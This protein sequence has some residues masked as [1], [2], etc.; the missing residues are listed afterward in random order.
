MCAWL[1]E[2][3]GSSLICVTKIGHSSTRHV[4]SCASQHTEHQHK[5]SLTYV[6]CVTF[7]YLSDSRLCCPRIHLPTAEIHGRMALLRNT[8]LSQVMSPKGSHPTRTSKTN[9]YVRCWLHH[10]VGKLDAESVQNREA[11][12]QRAQAY[13]SRRESLMSSSFMPQ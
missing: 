3:E 10:C 4:S 13:H 9:N 8:N 7:V 11:N 5:F 12:A 1:K 6:S 2:I